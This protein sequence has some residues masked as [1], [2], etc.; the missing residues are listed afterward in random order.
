MG[1]HVR[2]A[3]ALVFLLVAT[4]VHAQ[5][6]PLTP[7]VQKTNVFLIPDTDAPPAQD[8]FTR[9]MPISDAMVSNVNGQPLPDKPQLVAREGQW[10]AGGEP[11][12]H[13]SDDLVM[14]AKKSD[15]RLMWH[16]EKVDSCVWCGAPMT[17]K[18]A[19]FDKKGSSMWALRSALMVA[20]I[21]ITH[22]M[23]CFQ[24]RTCRESN[25]LLGQ[26]RLQGYSVAAGLTAFSW[27]GD[28]WLRKGSR[29]YRIGGYRHWW[30]VPTVGYAASALGIITN[31][32]TWHS[33]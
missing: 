2:I 25:P 18:Q 7:D 30:I 12:P 33:R 13:F 32:A 15:G 21:E 29:E 5:D 8:Q 27:I 17:W 1:G 14:V 23:P 20:N 10:I 16:V 31:L 28:A 3:S 19:M 11:L 24:A 22:H 6:L 9:N 26:T 4:T